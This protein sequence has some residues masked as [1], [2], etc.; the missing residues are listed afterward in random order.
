MRYCVAIAVVSIISGSAFGESLVR[1]VDV[2]K[3]MHS[4]GAFSVKRKGADAYGE[5]LDL[6]LR[7]LA[8]FKC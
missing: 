7:F 6:Q 4:C 1:G 3:L 5:R 2:A 8:L